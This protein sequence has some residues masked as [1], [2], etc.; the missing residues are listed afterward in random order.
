[1]ALE[2]QINQ[3]LKSALL[4]G[5]KLKV[6][7]LRGLKSVFLYAKVATGGAGR[8][9]EL[10]DEQLLPL[11]AKEAKKRQESITLYQQAGETER[12]EKEQNEKAIIET[13]LPK[14]LD[15]DAIKALIDEAVS[16]L[17]VSDMS[18]MGKVIADVKQASQ[19]AAD[20]AVIARL[21]KERLSQ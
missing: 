10:T 1:M 20:G 2:Q 21:V 9:T 3:D 11:I 6:E 5:E 13:Y 8:D 12:A 18:G 17:E 19:G 4:N 16:H 14:Q 7:T 15:E